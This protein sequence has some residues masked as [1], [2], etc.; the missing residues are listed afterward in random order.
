MESNLGGR[1]F[2]LEAFPKINMV[3]QCEEET[4]GD[5][6]CVQTEDESHFVNTR[7]G[8]CIGRKEYLWWEGG[9]QWVPRMGIVEEFRTQILFVH[10]NIRRGVHDETIKERKPFVRGLVCSG[11]S[12]NSHYPQSQLFLVS[13]LIIY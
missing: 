13:L 12:T 1:G 2:L 5:Q 6:Q 8:N 4:K 7:W 3:T 10:I 9:R 11:K